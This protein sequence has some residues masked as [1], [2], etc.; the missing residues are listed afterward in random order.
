MGASDT[1]RKGRSDLAQPDC[2]GEL[3]GKSNDETEDA[4]YRPAIQKALPEAALDRGQ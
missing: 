2:N 4:D 1:Y 3:D